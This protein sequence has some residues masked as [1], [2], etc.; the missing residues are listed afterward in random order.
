MVFCFKQF[1]GVCKGMR[2][3][4]SC[5]ARVEERVWNVDGRRALRVAA[6][7]GKVKDRE[8][9]EFCVNEGRMLRGRWF[10]SRQVGEMRFYV[11][12]EL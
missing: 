8:T 1:F 5:V 12:Y 6:N 11:F 10:A 2:A 9:Q 7:M 4:W 3:G